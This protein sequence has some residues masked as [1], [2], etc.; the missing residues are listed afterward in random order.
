M[1]V[2]ARSSL[3]RALVG[4]A[5]LV[6]L[7]AGASPAHAATSPEYLGV[8]LQPLQQNPTIPESRWPAYLGTLQNG[9]MA[10]NRIQADWMIMEP[11]APVNGVHDFRWDAG[12]GTRTSMDY[13][14]AQLALRGLR[15]LPTMNNSPQWAR[16]NGSNLPDSSFPAFADFTVA[17]LQR[18][19]PGGTFWAANPQ[20]PQYPV[21]TIELWNEPN[22]PNSWSGRADAPAYARFLQVVY[23]AA[24]RAVPSVTV[25]ASLAW[26]NAAGFL[27][28]VFQNGAG[29]SMDAV[30]LH[31]Y[32][33]TSPAA[34]RLV[35][36]VRSSL[37]GQGRGDLPL[38]IAETGQ[39]ATYDPVGAKHAYA[40]LVT[41]RTRAAT[42]ALTAEALAHSDCNVNSYLVYAITGSETSKEQLSE[43]F[44]G[45]T[46]FA[47]GSPNA[48]GVA[49]QRASTR[50]ASGVDSGTATSAGRLVLCNPGAT[51]PAALLRLDLSVQRGSSG[52]CVAGAIGYDG[53]PLEEASLV[54][55]TPD[56]RQKTTGSDAT[57]TTEACIPNGPATPSVD[58]Y[59]EVPGAAR[60]AVIRCAVPIA[61]CVTLGAGQGSS[62]G[63]G[64]KQ[65][66]VS[67]A[68]SVPKRDRRGTRASTK[69]RAKLRCTAYQTKKTVKKKV[70][71]GKTASG[72][73]RYKLKKVK[74]TVQPTFSVLF[75]PKGKAK[76][77]KLR[78]ITL[79]HGKTIVFT[80]RRPMKK[81]DAVIVKHKVTKQDA[82]PTVRNLVLLRAPKR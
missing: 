23:P 32:A 12:S 67:M 18:Y 59:A 17:F 66:L 50:W 6:T 14:I 60:S 27:A 68:A 19:G 4:A 56:G 41:D 65:C 31:A 13:T 40:G 30:A 39:P 71:V 29:A 35:A 63:N 57:G 28:S 25:A 79:K 74:V 22:S 62:A 49:L 46:R 77:R 20:L 36:S 75:D 80:V 73:P 61:N 21:T 76:S 53:N 69:V 81:G 42:L 43:G 15:A 9:R 58:V 47:D 55:T 7:L 37:A 78:S 24:K 11:V 48:T 34:F 64:S 1:R 5:L 45:I 3:H 54:I 16:G 8:N 26:D 72:K 70:R 2:F 10:I 33:P 52:G 38:W 82:L 44:M 51:P